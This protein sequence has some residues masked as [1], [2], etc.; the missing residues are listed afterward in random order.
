MTSGRIFV[1]NSYVAGAPVFHVTVI[2]L[3]PEDP[4][5]VIV[6]PDETTQV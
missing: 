1:V 2:V 6:P 4:P 5:E 3:L